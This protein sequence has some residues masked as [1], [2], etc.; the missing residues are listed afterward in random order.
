MGDTVFFN[1]LRPY[2]TEQVTVSSA[3]V[4][5]TTAKVDNTANYPDFKA[6]GVVLAVRDDSVYYTTD[7]TTPSSTNGLLLNNGD[8][9]PLAG[10]QK[11]KNFKA[12]RVTT[13]AKLDVHYYKN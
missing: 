4:S 6:A 11:I 12:I 9:L 10:Y 1:R 3:A 7:G 13:D 2:A 8:V 5:L